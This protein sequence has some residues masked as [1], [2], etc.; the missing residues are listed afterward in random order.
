MKPLPR[1]VVYPVLSA[2]VV[3]ALVGL[4]LVEGQSIF[5][6]PQAPPAKPRQAT[7]AKPQPGTAA[8][9][10]AP[11]TAKPQAPAP[12]PKPQA[13]AAAAKPQTA[14]PAPKPQAPAAAAKPPAAPA[15]PA[16]AA[17]AGSTP[18]ATAAS[19]DPDLAPAGYTYDPQGRRDPFVSLLQRGGGIGQRPG[20]GARAPG[21][22]GL[23]TSEVTL[24]GT[25]LSQGA[26]VGIVQGSDNKTY[27]VKSGD[28]LADGEIRSIT[29]DTMVIIQQVTDPLSLEKQREVRKLL[30]PTTEEA[31]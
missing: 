31:K 10:Q 26:Y 2:V 6:T 4:Y 8:K 11:A 5:A 15:A 7:P 13:P 1:R 20:A 12:A 29:P 18:P 16:P 14:A 23:E 19:T 17:T 28:K 21:L 9:P 25:L 27:I 30:R 22:A 24:R 3:A